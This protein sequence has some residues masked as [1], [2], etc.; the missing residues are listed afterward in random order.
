MLHGG[1]QGVAKRKKKTKN[2][3]VTL[4]AGE[5]GGKSGEERAGEGNLFLIS[6][7]NKLLARMTKKKRNRRHKLPTAGMKEVL[8]TLQTDI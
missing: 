1:G 5:C 7:S 6:K 2:Q 4:V 8:Q 3:N